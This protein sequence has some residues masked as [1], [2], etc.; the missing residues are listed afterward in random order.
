MT[1]DSSAQK[2]EQSRACISHRTRLTDIVFQFV[3]LCHS[4]PQVAV[5]EYLVLLHDSRALG[6]LLVLAIQS[7][8]YVVSSSKDSRD[9]G[10]RILYPLLHRNRYLA[11]VNL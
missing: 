4:L 6:C 8:P 5:T 10:Q 2:I 1:L 9:K 3:L 7:Q 11:E